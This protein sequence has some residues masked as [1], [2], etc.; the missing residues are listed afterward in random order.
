M[1]EIRIEGQSPFHFPDNPERK[2]KKITKADPTR[3]VADEYDSNETK[4]GLVARNQF[5]DRAEIS[6]A[7]LDRSRANQ[8]TKE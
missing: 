5:G 1:N 6:Q 7:A 4:A 3:P 8:E 2:V